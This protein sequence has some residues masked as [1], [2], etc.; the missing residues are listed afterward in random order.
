MTGEGRIEYE[1]GFLTG[2]G[3]DGIPLEVHAYGLGARFK[4][5]PRQRFVVSD[6]VLDWIWQ[7]RY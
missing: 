6:E 4:A 2:G 1:Q 5:S 7:R 3:Y